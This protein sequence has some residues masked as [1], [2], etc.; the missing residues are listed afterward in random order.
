MKAITLIAATALLAAP[1]FA[2]PTGD[3]TEGEKSFGRRCVACHVVKDDAGE[4]LAGRNAR[5]GPNLYALEGRVIG[6][7]E[8]YRYGKSLAAV[9]D[10]NIQWDEEEFVAY[11][12]DPTAWLRD[13]LTDDKARSKM[14]F[15]LRDEQE[16]RDIYAFL[17][18]LQN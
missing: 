1:A 12:Q 18:S 17:V 16:A 15:K 11:V 8:G 13:A 3:A 7:V 14:A 4:T 2:D 9:A 5:T 6:T 10:E